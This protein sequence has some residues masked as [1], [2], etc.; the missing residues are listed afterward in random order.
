MRSQVNP[1]EKI[2]EAKKLA[3]HK[4][5]PL[6]GTCFLATTQYD[7]SPH[8]RAMQLYDLVDGALFLLINDTSPKW[9]Q[10]TSSASYEALIYLPSVSMQARFCG[11]FFMAEKRIAEKYW[12]QVPL[13]FKKLDYFHSMFLD[14]SS[15]QFDEKKFYENMIFITETYKDNPNLALPDHV[16]GV[17]L[18]P[19]EIEIWMDTKKGDEMPIRLLYIVKDNEWQEQLLVP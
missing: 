17:Y 18:V 19:T 6:H 7:K 12:T 16:K 2:I 3:N 4:G 11:A 15:K 9:E 10:L 8:V 1:V 5:D 14:Q 13:R